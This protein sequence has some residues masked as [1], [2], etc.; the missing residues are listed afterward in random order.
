MEKSAKWA[1][2]MII[3]TNVCSQLGQMLM[4]AGPLPANLIAIVSI[5]FIAMFSWICA[6]TQDHTRSYKDPGWFM[7]ILSVIEDSSIYLNITY[8]WLDLITQVAMNY[9]WK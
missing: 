2:S 3:M 6:S 7:N 4:Y 1:L 5:E 9:S 8:E